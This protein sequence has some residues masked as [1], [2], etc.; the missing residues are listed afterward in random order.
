MREHGRERERERERDSPSTA[1]TR[2]RRDYAPTD[3]YTR[4]L[5]ARTAARD[6]RTIV[7][8]SFIVRAR[9]APDRMPE[10]RKR[11]RDEPQRS[12]QRF[13]RAS[14]RVCILGEKT[15]D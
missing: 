15:P 10:T 3:G 14:R 4:A 1:V 12:E 5:G 8:V 11:Q 2:R 13:R 6:R 7:Y 9:R